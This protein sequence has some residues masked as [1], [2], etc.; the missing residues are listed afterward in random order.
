[1]GNLGFAPVQSLGVLAISGS[2]FG[3]F[4][5]C[6][7]FRG[8]TGTVQISVTDYTA[9]SAG[10][11][12]ITGRPDEGSNEVI[13]Y[14]LDLTSLTANELVVTNLF[15]FPRMRYAIISGTSSPAAFAQVHLQE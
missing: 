15:I 13:V 5:E 10:T 12:A 2:P 6:Q 1:M 11:L 8:E 3:T 9:I 7:R 4:V 14:S